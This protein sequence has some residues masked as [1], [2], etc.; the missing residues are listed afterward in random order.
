M[1]NEAA[2]EDDAAYG[3]G[4]QQPL[5]HHEKGRPCAASEDDYGRL[6]NSEEPSSGLGHE[7]EAPRAHAETFRQR[8]H[9]EKR[10]CPRPTHLLTDRSELELFTP[11][12]E[13]FE[14]VAEQD[15]L[16]FSSQQCHGTLSISRC[17]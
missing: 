14:D 5:G 7:E 8:E 1:A 6:R 13:L 4:G 9:P 11:M 3:D 10:F 15:R 2:H 16:T 12:V 17:I